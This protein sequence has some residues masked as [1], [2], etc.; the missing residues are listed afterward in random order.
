VLYDTHIPFTDSVFNKITFPYYEHVKLQNFIFDDL[1]TI[2][3]Y[4]QPTFTF[5]HITRPHTPFIFRSDG[6]FTTD[7][8]YFSGLYE[9]PVSNELFNAGYVN[10]VGYVN[11]KIINVVKEIISNSST[12]PI[13]IIQGDHG[14]I[15]DDRLPVLNAYY[16]PGLQDSGLYSSISPVNS[17]RLLF[18]KYFNSDYPILDDQ[19]YNSSY[20]YLYDWTQVAESSPD[21]INQ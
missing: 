13:I 21:C 14:A 6:T 1:I 7:R 4:P 11:Q 5:A 3:T 17:F 19:S 16:F 18:D 9:Y 10:Q 15:L 8:R 12:P 2:S 20:E